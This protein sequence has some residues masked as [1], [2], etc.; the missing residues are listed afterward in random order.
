MSHIR[1]VLLTAVLVAAGLSIGAFAVVQI[2]DIE[3][4]EERANKSRTPTAPTT[5][6]AAGATP[7]APPSPTPETAGRL[8]LVTFTA[9]A[10]DQ[11]A[12]EVAT[13]FDEFFSAINAGDYDRALKYYDPAGQI[14]TTDPAERADFAEGVA[15]STDSDI[16][17]KSLGED[18]STGNVVATVSFTSVQAPEKAP[19]GQTCAHWTVAYTLSQP[20]GAYRI[21]KGNASHDSCY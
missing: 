10:G 18:P 14:D 15:T 4:R 7:T 12:G 9:V 21:F 3:P 20:G 6:R 11:R 19:N 2:A 16:V 13:M 17:L 1:V 8:G 5:A